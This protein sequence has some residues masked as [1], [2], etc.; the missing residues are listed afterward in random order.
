[1]NTLIPVYA[2]KTKDGVIIWRDE[3]KE[4]HFATF[5]RADHF[6][7]PNK[8]NKTVMLNC[9]RWRLIWL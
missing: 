2:E 5:Y 9:C 8:R 6:K 7:L 1:M 4:K 3:N